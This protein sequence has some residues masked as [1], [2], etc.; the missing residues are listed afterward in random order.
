M[1]LVMVTRTTTK[2]VIFAHPF[3]LAEE[4]ESFAAGEYLVQTDEE[5]IENLS[6]PAWRRVATSIEVRRDGATQVLPID[7][8]RLALI[9]SRDAVTSAK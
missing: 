9:L 7:P 2:M 4:G 3:V 5:M 6:F 8:K 1:G